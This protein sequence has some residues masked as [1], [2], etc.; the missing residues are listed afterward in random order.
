VVPGKAGIGDL[1]AKHGQLVAQHEDLG[2][3]RR[4]IR[5]VDAN[6][7]EHAPDQTVEEG[8][9]HRGGASPRAFRQVKPGQ[10]GFW[11]LHGSGPLELSAQEALGLTKMD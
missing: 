4:G 3:L 7:L 5:P 6:D 11:T 1:A 10:R 2:V 9:C 8:Q